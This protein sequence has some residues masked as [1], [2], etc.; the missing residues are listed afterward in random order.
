MGKTLVMKQAPQALEQVQT[1]NGK[2]YLRRTDVMQIFSISL[3]TLKNMRR[4]GVIPC[5]K[6]GKTYL[7]KREEIEACLVKIIQKRG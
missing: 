3:S 4:D 6:F 1:M 2:E 7:Y 5:Y